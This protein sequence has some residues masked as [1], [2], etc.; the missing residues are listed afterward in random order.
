M[1]IVINARVDVFITGGDTPVPQLL[2]TALERCRRYLEA[3]ADTVYPIGLVDEDAIAAVVDAAG[4]MVNIWARSDAPP[5]A[6]LR[7]LGVARVSAA[8]GLFNAAIDAAR[9][10]AAR[11]HGA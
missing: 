11:L 4:G 10:H 6:R 5:L 9:D 3:G 7:E 1:P 2:P 8:T